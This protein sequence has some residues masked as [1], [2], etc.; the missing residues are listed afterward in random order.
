[1]GIF[2]YTKNIKNK[3]NGHLYV[4][5]CLSIAAIDQCLSVY[6]FFLSLYIN[7][8]FFLNCRNT[9]FLVMGVWQA[10]YERPSWKKETDYQSL[11]PGFPH[12]PWSKQGLFRLKKHRLWAVSAL[13]Y[14]P[15]WTDTHLQPLLIVVSVTCVSMFNQL[16]ESWMHILDN[17]VCSFMD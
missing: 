10:K 11:H 15:W 17:N 12:S 2:L 16:A 3:G 4:V 9:A 13:P 14:K 6:L 8:R 7:C 1:M 5:V